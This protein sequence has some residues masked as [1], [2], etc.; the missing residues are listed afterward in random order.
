MDKGSRIL[1]ARSTSV[2]KVGPF[3]LKYKIRWSFIETVKKIILYAGS[4]IL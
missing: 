1:M 2:L 3:Y 4:Y